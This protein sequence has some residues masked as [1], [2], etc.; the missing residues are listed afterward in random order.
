MKQKSIGLKLLFRGL[1]LLLLLG[2]LGLLYLGSRPIDRTLHTQL[3]Q[4]I[5]LLKTANSLLNEELIQTKANMRPHYDPLVEAITRL[6][7]SAS[8]IQRLA[9]GKWGGILDRSI[10]AVNGVI[11]SKRARVENFKSHHAVLRNSTHYLPL[12][13]DQFIT[14]LNSQGEGNEN[15]R[16][17]LHLLNSLLSF[18]IN[19]DPKH[20]AGARQWMKI[21]EIVQSDLQ[22]TSQVTLDSLLIHSRLVMEYTNDVDQLMEQGAQILLDDE[23][24]RMHRIYQHYSEDRDADAALYRTL[25]FITSA[26]LLIAVIAVFVKLQLASTTLRQAMTE[27]NFQKFA[28]DQHALVSI[29]DAK[30]DITYVNQQ[31]CELSGYSSEELIGQNHRIVKSDAHSRE[32][33]RD[34]WRTI[35]K[36]E[37]W[38]GE[39]K[40]HTKEGGY[41]WVSA[42]IVPFL[43]GQGKPFQ[44]VSIRTNITARKRMEV[45]ITESRRFLQGVTDS[46]GEG[47]YA[48]DSAGLC[49][50]L[51]PEA[52]KLFGHSEKAWLG[53]N[54]HL[55]AHDDC[56][57]DEGEQAVEDCPILR[58]VSRGDTFRSDNEWFKRQDGSIFPAAVVSVPLRDSEQIVGSVTVFQDIT[59]RKQ[60]EQ[61]MRDAQRMAEEA[62]KAKGDFLANMS[63]EIRTPMNAIIGLSHLALQTDLNPRQMNYIEKV[64]LSAEALLGI[65]NDIL[66]FSKIEAGKMDVE[67]VDFRLEDLLDNLANLMGL[68]AEEKG[69]ELLLYTD[70][71]VPNHLVGDPLRLGQILINLTNNAVKFTAEGEVVIRISLKETLGDQVRLEFSV[72][73]SGIGLTAEQQGRLFQSFS[74]ADS[75]TTRKYG[76]TGLGLAIS[77]QL[78]ELME[79]EIWVESEKDKGSIFLFNVLLGQQSSGAE[80]VAIPQGLNLDGFRVLLVHDNAKAREV[81]ESIL[82]SFHFRPESV[83]NGA[84]GLGALQ[85]ALAIGDPYKLVLVDWQMPGMDGVEFSNSLH[86]LP[87]ME[88]LHTIVMGSATGREALLTATAEVPASA[89]LTKPITPSTLLD[90]IMEMF[91]GGTL[92]HPRAGT[93]HDEEIE[94]INHLRGAH[95]LLVEDNTINQEL[96]LELLANN[97]ITADLAENGQEALDAISS[98]HYDGVLM[99]VQ[100][101]VMD[102]YTATRKLRKNDEYQLLPVIAMTANAM[103]EDREQAKAV[104]MNDC[105]TKPINVCDMFTTMARW[106]TPSTPLTARPDTSPDK[107][108]TELDLPDIP[109]LDTVAGLA[110]TQGNTMLYH[111]LLSKYF[112]SRHDFCSTF[113]E[114]LEQGDIETAERLAHTLNGVSGNIGAVKVQAAASTLEAACSMKHDRAHLNSLMKVV[115]Q[116][117]K[118]VID[119]LGDW[120]S[121]HAETEET[122]KTENIATDPER[123]SELLQQ[124]RELLDDDDT[125]ASELVGELVQATGSSIQTDRLT[126][127][128][129]NYDFR[130]AREVLDELIE[131]MM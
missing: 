68:K 36:G 49:T 59:L 43:D 69:L 12:V 11:A 112:D 128:I 57:H 107:I 44:Y 85:Q 34:L 56:I 122:E 81:L 7:R 35:A 17:A 24:D 87:G 41:Y 75:S 65:I 20:E 52:V 28:L 80:G 123:V 47:I 120:L 66:D 18:S 72:E 3:L 26:I 64:H 90:S 106:I 111:K 46:M 110:T 42:T 103:V 116:L 82:H 61:E 118:P 129:G 39:V 30:G 115:E 10:V 114:A 102:G 71:E 98:N 2:A 14:Q 54:I 105:I 108:D 95:L 117:Y 55:L 78:V 22:P 79:G 101:P 88:T 29:T 74:Q 51:N 23:I 89:V 38:H 125:D 21:L 1:L 32:F 119:G 37:V 53:H 16:A 86:Q 99:D 70:P 4:Q 40:N 62:S 50:Y 19:S 93:R 6:E 127:L 13:T 126:R 73:D 77:K 48:L 121:A 58:T 109:G 45:E 131:T 76:G 27:L 96:A 9:E 63:H 60:A 124:M 5:Y 31:F 25:L 91:G 104:G 92:E 130:A 8:E 83:C 84:E 97:D 100:M 94:A 113:R 67:S 15:H 33:F